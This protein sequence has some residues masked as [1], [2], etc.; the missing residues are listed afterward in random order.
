MIIANSY[1]GAP[2]VTLGQL[3]YLPS[4]VR[5][6]L[7]LREAFEYLNFITIVKYD[8]TQSELLSF[9]RSLA[10]NFDE[11]I[12][13]RFVFAFYGYIQDDFVFCGDRNV[14]QLSDILDIISNHDSL[15]NIPQIFFFDVNQLTRVNTQI[16][17]NGNLILTML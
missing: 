15:M 4:S 9:L 5:D 8:V 11:Q 2:G 7:K 6:A 13:D 17:K 14:I 1:E 12:C 16:L 10:Y 3:Q